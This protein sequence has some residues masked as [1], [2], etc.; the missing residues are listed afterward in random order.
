M[1]QAPNRMFDEFAKLMTDSSKKLNCQNPLE[2]SLNLLIQGFS[3]ESHAF[4][5][6]S[7]GIRESGLYTDITG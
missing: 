7:G 3:T 5:S 4:Q 6:L 2:Q 1:S